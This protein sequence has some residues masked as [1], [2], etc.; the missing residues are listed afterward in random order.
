MNRRALSHVKR[1]I[2]R[3]TG[4]PY[5]HISD[6]MALLY[7]REN[8]IKSAAPQRNQ[9]L[10]LIN[11]EIEAKGGL[12]ILTYDMKKTTK[13]KEL[14]SAII[15]RAAAGV[16]KIGQALFEL[17]QTLKRPKNTNNMEFLAV[18]EM[19][20]DEV[21]EIIDNL[22]EAERGQINTG[23]L[24]GTRQVIDANTRSQI[25]QLYSILDRLNQQIITYTQNNE[26]EDWQID[27]LQAFIMSVNV[28]YGSS[29]EPS[30]TTLETA[31]EVD[32]WHRVD[33]A[34][35]FFEPISQMI[36]N[37]LRG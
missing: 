23:R 1:Y 37:V 11:E 19:L 35:H 10:N 13:R 5:Q 29:D 7:N 27:Q 21:R 31:S 8:T 30:F 14:A 25:P 32:W 4:V 33:N 18:W 2:S 17:R 28:Y 36:N 9:T 12:P 6:N 15:M 24:Q 26:V 16:K 34:T 20:R 3:Q 22:S